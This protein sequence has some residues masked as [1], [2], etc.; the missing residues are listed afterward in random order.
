[1]QPFTHHRGLVVAMDRADVDTDQVI[2]KQFL[3]RIER[4]GFGQFL[5]FDWR[6]LPDGTPNP[7]F[8]LNRPGA[9]GCSILLARD[10]FGCGSSR[11]HAVWALADYG[12]RS[13]VAPSFADIFFNN[14]FKNGMLPVILGQAV[15]DQLFANAAGGDYH[16]TVDLEACQVRDDD[17]LER[18]F[19][20]DVFRRRCLLEGLDDIALTLQHEDRISAFEQ[21]RGG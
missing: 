2:P 1:M 5:F 11:E 16:L 7:E 19:P 15:I 20:V 9:E 4:S 14:C 21:A 12:I 18:D 10:N 8:E 6:F 3:K 13:V 17:G